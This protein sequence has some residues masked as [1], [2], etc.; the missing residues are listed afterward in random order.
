MLVIYNRV[1]SIFNGDDTYF[2]FFYESLGAFIAF[3]Y[4]IVFDFV[5][6]FSFYFFIFLSSFIYFLD[7]FSDFY[8]FCYK[9]LLFCWEVYGITKSSQDFLTPYWTIFLYWLNFY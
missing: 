8:Y 7:F 9:T 1:S 2:L 3:T 5:L 4:V 6:L